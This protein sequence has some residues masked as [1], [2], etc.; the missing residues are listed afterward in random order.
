MQPIAQAVVELSACAVSP[1]SAWM[2]ISARHASSRSGSSSSSR[3]A[4]TAGAVPRPAGEQTGHQPRRRLLDRPRSRWRSTT[5]PLLEGGVA[6]ADAVEQ[7]AAVER[8]RRLASPRAVPVARAARS[9]AA[10]STLSAAGSSRT[11]WRS[12]TMAASPSRPERCAQPRQGVLEAVA[13]LG[14]AAVAPQQPREPVPGMRRA[15]RQGEHGQQ[16]ALLL[17]RQVP[18]RAVR[19]PTSNPPS[20]VTARAAI[21]SSPARRPLLED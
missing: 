11:D 4:A 13:R 7:V 5:Q 17:P 19:R 10:T 3:R 16:R 14:V 21:P 20:S 8:D 1:R 12:A 2:R 6:H 18:D 9:N 15:R